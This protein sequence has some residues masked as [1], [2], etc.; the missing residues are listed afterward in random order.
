V[1]EHYRALSGS[2]NSTKSQKAA[3]VALQS[4]Y[5]VELQLQER[6]TRG[7]PS[8]TDAMQNLNQFMF[9]CVLSELR[10]EGHSSL[11]S[12]TWV[13]RTLS[14][15]ARLKQKMGVD[16]D[17]P[18]SGDGVSHAEIQKA[19]AEINE[20]YIWASNARHI[21]QRNWR[22]VE[23][24]I[25][26][27]KGQNC[28]FGICFPQ[29]DR[30]PEAQPIA[31]V[32]LAL[33]RWYRLRDLND[34]FPCELGLTNGSRGLLLYIHGSEPLKPDVLLM[35]FPSYCGPSLLSNEVWQLLQTTSVVQQAMAQEPALGMDKIVPVVRKK[36]RYFGAGTVLVIYLNFQHNNCENC[37]AVH[38]HTPEHTQLVGRS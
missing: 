23:L 29:G 10:R 34:I 15:S 36:L 2:T 12:A 13:L 38:I 33:N 25:T 28:P 37:T 3:V 14:V 21:C 32:V 11:F 27:L 16:W 1:A 24:G 18:V 17:K 22:C 9:R 7:I 35:Y 5:A 30:S 19:T 26:A 4:C 31:C 6:F 8:G 20:K